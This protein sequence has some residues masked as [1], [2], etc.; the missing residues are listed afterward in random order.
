MSLKMLYTSNFVIKEKKGRTIIPDKQNLE[1]KALQMGFMH[2]K[3]KIKEK[4]KLRT[5]VT[6]TKI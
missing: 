3:T 5:K 1:N 4:F 2:L 6:E